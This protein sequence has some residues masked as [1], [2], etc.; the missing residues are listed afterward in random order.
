MPLVIFNYYSSQDGDIPLDHYRQTLT[1]PRHAMNAKWKLEAINAVYYNED[2]E[3]FKHLEIEFPELM[4]TQ[5][6]LY[7]TT[8][9][10]DCELPECSF[11]ISAV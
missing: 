7:N 6:F 10:G 4:T 8:S 1:I 9:I 3:D 2:K 11:G 5:N